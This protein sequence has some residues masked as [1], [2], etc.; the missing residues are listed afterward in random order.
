MFENLSNPYTITLVYLPLFLGIVNNILTE[1]SLKLK[2]GMKTMGLTDLAFYLSYILT[3]LIQYFIVSMIAIAITYFRS[4][5]F[6]I[7]LDNIFCYLLMLLVQSI[8]FV[9]FGCVL[10]TIFDSK[11]KS[12]LIILMGYV[13]ST[14]IVAN[15]FAHEKL[16]PVKFSF[17]YN[18][19]F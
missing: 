1:K 14:V 11:M 7:S 19:L 15:D 12:N 8:V 3:Y 5:Q 6:Y 10:S 17:F 13:F 16:Q 18:I 2:E 4:N 9:L